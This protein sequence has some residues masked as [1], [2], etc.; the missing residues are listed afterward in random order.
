MAFPLEMYSKICP[1]KLDLVSHIPK[2][3]KNYL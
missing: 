1:I 3:V 2:W